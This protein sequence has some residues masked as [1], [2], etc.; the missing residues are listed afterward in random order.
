MPPI[1]WDAFIADRKLVIGY[2]SDFN[3]GDY[4]V[5]YGASSENLD[6]EFVTN[7]R[8]MLSIDLNSEKEIFFKIKRNS[9]GKESNWSQIVKVT[10][11]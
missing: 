7:A 6:K 8:G 4:T 1:I 2:S 9:D 11:N 3:D 10:T 5:Q